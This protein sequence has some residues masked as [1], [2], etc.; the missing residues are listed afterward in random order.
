M[1][2]NPV[3]PVNIPIPTKID[4]NGWC[5]YPKMVPLD[6]T[7]SHVFVS[8]ASDA[9]NSISSRRSRPARRARKRER[10]RRWSRQ[11]LRG[12][13]AVGK[14]RPSDVADASEQRPKT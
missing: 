3:P 1:G 13:A 8:Q 9:Q 12:E 4:K 7:H 5:T 6:S 10:E 11:S 14:C 2:Q